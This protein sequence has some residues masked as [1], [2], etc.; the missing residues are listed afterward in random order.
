MSG[1]IIRTIAPPVLAD[2]AWAHPSLV[3]V[4]A[5]TSGSFTLQLVLDESGVFGNNDLTCGG[6]SSSIS[7]SRGL[8]VTSSGSFITSSCDVSHRVACCAAM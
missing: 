6:W 8:V 7:V 3:N 4:S 2:S 1:E 5:A